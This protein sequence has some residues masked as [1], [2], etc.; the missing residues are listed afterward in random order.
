MNIAY[1]NRYAH[2]YFFFFSSD[3]PLPRIDSRL[4]KSGFWATLVLEETKARD[5]E[6]SSFWPTLM[7]LGSMIANIAD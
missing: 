2:H 4:E 1:S 3:K 5:I 6:T 7:F